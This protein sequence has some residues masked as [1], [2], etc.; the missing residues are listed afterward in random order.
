MRRL[1]KSTETLHSFFLAFFIGTLLPYACNEEPPGPDAKGVPDS[2]P[3]AAICP[4]GSKAED[5]RRSHQKNKTVLFLFSTES[6]LVLRL[7]RF[8]YPA[9]TTAAAVS[10]KNGG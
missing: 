2:R 8:L 3:S 1:H 7:A 9:T 4:A 6:F 5:S 10:P